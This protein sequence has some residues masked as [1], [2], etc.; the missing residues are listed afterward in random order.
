MMGKVAETY[1]EFLDSG[2][3]DLGYDYSTVPLFSELDMILKMNISVWDYLGVTEKDYY[4]I[5]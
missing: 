2:G 1:D 5:K 3:K 4:S